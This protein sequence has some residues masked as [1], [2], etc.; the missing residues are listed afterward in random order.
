VRLSAYQT[1][2]GE[3]VERAYA[4]EMNDRDCEEAFGFKVGTPELRDT[5]KMLRGAGHL[6]CAGP[7]HLS[8]KVRVPGELFPA[9]MYVV[10]DCA[11]AGEVRALCRGLCYDA[12]T[13]GQPRRM[14]AFTF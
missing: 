7:G 6:I 14:R 9:R 1:R 10:R 13:T 3:V 8:A 11:S 12:R 2:D 5:L 4:C